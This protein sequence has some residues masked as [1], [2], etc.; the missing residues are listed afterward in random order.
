MLRR[1]VRWHS[2]S[3]GRNEKENDRLPV[4]FRRAVVWYEVSWGEGAA[5]P[6][7]TPSQRDGVPCGPYACG[8][9]RTAEC[10]GPKNKRVESK[11]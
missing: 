2:G 9:Q 6:P 5:E 3:Y 10:R 8:L 1:P 11:K 7:S 4:L